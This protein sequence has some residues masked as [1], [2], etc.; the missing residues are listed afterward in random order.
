MPISIPP[1]VGHM[2]MTVSTSNGICTCLFLTLAVEVFVAFMG[3]DQLPSP[4]AKLPLYTRSQYHVLLFV[5]GKT[6]A[7]REKY[8]SKS[9][10]SGRM[11]H[12]LTVAYVHACS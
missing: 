2:H 3:D 10:L 5:G 4:S 6:V 12:V 8:A 1:W 11:T 7:S 9:R